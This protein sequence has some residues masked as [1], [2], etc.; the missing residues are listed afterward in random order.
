MPNTLEMLA[1]LMQATF[2]YKVIFQMGEPRLNNIRH[3]GQN[4][5]AKTAKKNR[6]TV[7]DY[8]FNKWWR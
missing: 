4:S 5:E 7:L 3:L 8:F 1:Y 2:F 6:T